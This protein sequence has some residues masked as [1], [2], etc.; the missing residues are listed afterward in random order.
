MALARL[1]GGPLDGQVI[2]LDDDTDDSLIV[3]YGE[4]QLIYTRS[5]D[6]A[7]T[8]EGDGPSEAVFVFGEATENINPGEGERA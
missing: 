8:G 3:A 4:G 7:H 5:G 1:T 6:L 2:P